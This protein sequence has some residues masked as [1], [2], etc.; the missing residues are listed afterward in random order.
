MSS[1]SA[2]NP[3]RDQRR[4]P[5]A[6]RRTSRRRPGPDIEGI[7]KRFT[8]G[9]LPRSAPEISN[10]DEQSRFEFSQLVKGM[11]KD[12]RKATRAERVKRFSDEAAGRLGA[13]QA[14]LGNKPKR[15]DVDVTRRVPS[16]GTVGPPEASRGMQLADQTVEAFHRTQEAV[17][18]FPDLAEAMR[19]AEP[20]KDRSLRGMDVLRKALRS[21][22]ITASE[23]S[24]LSDANL[25]TEDFQFA[26]P[27]EGTVGPPDPGQFPT[28]R[29]GSVG[30]P[31]TTAQRRGA[32]DFQRDIRLQ[33]QVDEDPDRFTP[34]VIEEINRRREGAG[35]E[36]L[37]SPSPSQEPSLSPGEGTLLPQTTPNGFRA[38]VVPG[39][40]VE[41]LDSNGN[42]LG[43]GM[44]GADGKPRLNT[45]AMERANLA[46]IEAVGEA[47]AKAEFDA[48]FD[49]PDFVKAL[50]SQYKETTAR[51]V[52]EAFER[53]AEAILGQLGRG[54]ISREEA[55]SLIRGE[56]SRSPEDSV[57]G[58]MKTFLKSAVE[59]DT[60]FDRSPSPSE[61]TLEEQFQGRQTEFNGAP[62]QLDDKGMFRAL[63]DPE[64]EQRE[65]QQIRISKGREQAIKQ[66]T[67][68]RKR[69]VELI[70]EKIGAMEESLR[71]GVERFVD[72]SP[73]EQARL[74][75]EQMEQIQTEESLAE[76]EYVQANIRDI[77]DFLQLPP[78]TE[79]GRNS[80]NGKTYF[81]RPDGVWV[82]IEGNVGNVTSDKQAD[83]APRENF[84]DVI[85]HLQLPL[86]T[87]IAI[88]EETGDPYFQR[89]DGVWV[90][91]EG[92]QTPGIS[93]K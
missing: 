63:P 1:F 6:R 11:K 40:G 29:P 81:E 70:D 64:T 8:E 26:T 54:E 18:K 28:P 15:R 39:R 89:P 9:S 35:L 21:G 42:V 93:V 77:L 37:P 88:D 27:P 33:E 32:Q 84:D 12:R 4:S 74:V 19:S 68:A 38:R 67:E 25:F 87:P 52:I 58:R 65:A 49:N 53:E 44:I 5:S 78:D 62:G 55:A 66:A 34:S 82:D 91:S 76:W 51:P 43:P 50:V 22:R 13:A 16:E 92:R 31:P 86:D 10:L 80:E 46:R 79:I 45:A 30:P 57:I 83:S 72:K 71:E 7:A 75:Q 20:K 17:K 14:A 23:F 73:E 48:Q 24:A 85:D 2:P 69:A 60:L 61:A 36:P 59:N 90:D 3:T 41:I 56:G 47:A